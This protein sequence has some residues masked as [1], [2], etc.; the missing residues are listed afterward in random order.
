M[1]EFCCGEKR[2]Q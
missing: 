1:R 2:T